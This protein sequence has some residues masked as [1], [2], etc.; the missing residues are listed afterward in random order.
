MSGYLERLALSSIRAGSRLCIGIDP[1]LATLPDG[2][3]SVARLADWV[4]LLVDATVGHAAAYKV[5]IAFFEALGWEG[6][7]AAE[8][9]RG[10]V[11]ADVPLVVD[12]KRGDIG[13]TVAAQARALYDVLGAD[14]VTASPYLGI[15]ALAPLLERVDGFTYLL[16]RTSNPES[17]EFQELP[18]EGR[19]GGVPLYLRVADAA[20][21]RPEARAGRIGLVVGATAGDDLAVLRA[22]VPTLP[23]L[24]PGIGAQGGDV[25]ATVRHG[26]ARDGVAGGSVGGGLLVNVG[27]GISDGVA[28]AADPVAHLR[29]RAAEWGAHLAILAR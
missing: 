29:A 8:Q 15:G 4:R 27:R 13:S 20:A 3:R 10:I 17:A 28:D 18:V 21:A 22:R 5:N 23:F 12:A 1:D 6:M 16:C 2:Y 14:A 9:V 11:P 26:G 7:R 19:A 25:Q 24:V